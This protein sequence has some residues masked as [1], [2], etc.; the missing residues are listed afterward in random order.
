MFLT[1]SF[2]FSDNKEETGSP[3]KYCNCT[4]KTH[5][6]IYIFILF[7]YICQLKYAL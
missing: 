2:I 5:F 4:V 7:P 3:L 6:F 1:V